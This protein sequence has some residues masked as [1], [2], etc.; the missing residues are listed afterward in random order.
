MDT[1]AVLKLKGQIFLTGSFYH[2]TPYTRDGRFA[3]SGS[4][5]SDDDLY[6]LELMKTPPSHNNKDTVIH[7]SVG[8]TFPFPATPNNFTVRRPVRH[9]SGTYRIDVA[10]V[11]DYAGYEQ[12][13]K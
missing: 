10:V 6:M 8:A 2:L 13:H 3:T 1:M 11:V 12:F 5:T 9:A 4:A 7:K